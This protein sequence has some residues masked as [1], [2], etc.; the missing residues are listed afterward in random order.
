MPVPVGEGTT[1]GVAVGTGVGVIGGIGVGEGAT[2][3]DNSPPAGCVSVGVD[4]ASKVALTVT[5]A[6]P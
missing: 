4:M 3:V 5:V 2:G 6:S 1:A